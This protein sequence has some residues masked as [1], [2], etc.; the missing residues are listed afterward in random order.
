MTLTVLPTWA[1]ILGLAVRLALLHF[2]LRDLTL[3][4]HGPLTPASNKAEK[5]LRVKVG[6]ASKLHMGFVLTQPVEATS[7]V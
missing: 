4:L 3:D 2:S 6:F 7:K 5:V 1:P